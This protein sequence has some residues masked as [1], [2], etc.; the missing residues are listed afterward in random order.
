MARNPQDIL[1]AHKDL[2]VIREPYEKLKRLCTM[3]TYPMRSE[4]WDE[5]TDDKGKMRGRHYYDPTAP[6]ALEMWGNGIMGHYSPRQTPW[7][8]EIMPD[9]RLMKSK[10]VRK[11]L[12]DTDD[13]MHAT[14][15]KSNY[16]EAKKLS[17]TDS[18]CIG[19]SFVYI[20][21]DIETGKI[22]C[23]TPHPRQFYVR[24]D[25]FGRVVEIHDKFEKTIAQLKDEFGEDALSD[26]QKLALENRPNLP[27]EVIHATDRNPDYDRTKD[28]ARYM[29]WRTSFVNVPAKLTIKS[30]GYRTL[31]PVPWSLNRVSHEDYGRGIIGLILR[32][33]IT[34]NYIAYDM[35]GASQQSGH[36]TKVVHSALKNRWT[37]K[38]GADIFVEAEAL[39]GIKM[40]DLIANAFDNN[41]YPFGMDMLARWQGVIDERLGVPLFLAMAMME[42]ATDKTATEIRERK[43]E[44][45]VLM[46][47]FLGTLGST[48]DMELDRIHSIEL[49]AGRAPAPPLEVSGRVDVQYTGPLHQLLNFYYGTA[50]LLETIANIQAV[51]QMYPD[52]IV[53]VEGDELMRKILQSGNAPEEIVLEADEVAEIRA[54]AAQQAEAQMLAELAVKGGQANTGLSKAPE[55]GSPA[56]ALV[57]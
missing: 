3:L 56:Q 13:H 22:M 34:A 36:P 48:T 16:Y 47:P 51:A 24:R 21:Q 26:E 57:A 37:R 45:A 33:I 42:Q 20:D 1:K 25:Y 28:G 32:E 43:A 23:Q 8:R 15:A 6:K 40:G 54:I 55:E 52:S 17:V 4:I 7:F 19:D 50:N 35:L 10:V 2:I 53:V 11:W 14:L 29:K 46:A 5:V 30:G 12:Q 31:N 49:N 18:G 39:L 9:P 41:G 27:I 44:R 38:P